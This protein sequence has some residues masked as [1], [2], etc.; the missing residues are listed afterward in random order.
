MILHDQLASC[1]GDTE[2][3]YVSSLLLSL[4]KNQRHGKP[5]RIRAADPAHGNVELNMVEN[6]PLQIDTLPLHGL[7]LNLVDRHGRVH[8]HRELA[9]LKGEGHVGVSPC[10]SAGEWTS[11]SLCVSTSDDLAVHHVRLETPHDEVRPIRQACCAA[12]SQGGAAW[13]VRQQRGVQGGAAVKPQHRMNTTLQFFS[14][15][16]CGLYFGFIYFGFIFL[17]AYGKTVCCCRLER[18]HH[19]F[20]CRHRIPFQI[21]LQLISPSTGTPTS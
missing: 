20:P 5:D 2:S 4:S 3:M 6:W 19:A 17:L 15:L 14:C 18:H 1:V 11:C 21:C 12:R 16:R 8:T 7:P 9:A 13:C 10:V